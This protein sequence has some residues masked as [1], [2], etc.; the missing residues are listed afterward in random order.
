MKDENNNEIE[1]ILSDQRDNEENSSWIIGIIR[2]DKK[3]RLFPQVNSF[4]PY[5]DYRHYRR[6]SNMASFNRQQFSYYNFPYERNN[7]E[8]RLDIAG[9]DNL[10]AAAEIIEYC[11][12]SIN[13]LIVSYYLANIPY[14]VS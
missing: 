13:Y 10:P 6:Q 7:L 3:F 12:T 9:L 8:T 2:F 4:S 5:V 11:Q 14:K 1:L